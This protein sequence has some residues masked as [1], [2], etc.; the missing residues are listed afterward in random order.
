[1]INRAK[2][3]PNVQFRHPTTLWNKDKHPM[4]LGGY[5]CLLDQAH[6]STGP[7]PPCAPR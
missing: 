6:T 1:M 5:F 4:N 3:Y 7:P 2:K